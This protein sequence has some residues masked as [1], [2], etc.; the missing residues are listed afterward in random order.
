MKIRKMNRWGNN[1][2]SNMARSSMSTRSVVVS[3]S[4][5]IMIRRRGF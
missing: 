5:R 2:H 1:S 4:I 3:R